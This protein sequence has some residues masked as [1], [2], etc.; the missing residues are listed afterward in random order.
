MSQLASDG[1]ST[2]SS[3]RQHAPEPV[4][5]IGLSVLHEPAEGHA[6]TTTESVTCFRNTIYLYPSSGR[7]TYLVRQA[8]SSYTGCKDTRKG[9]GNALAPPQTP[10]R[11]R[12]KPRAVPS[13]DS[14][15]VVLPSLRGPTAPQPRPLNSHP[16]CQCSGQKTSS[17][18]TVQTHGF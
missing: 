8:L 9:P 11:P 6:L 16:A 4:S 2:A 12:R 7:L 14:S 5:P 15:T 17:H 13:L 10:T 18:K 3:S 1:S